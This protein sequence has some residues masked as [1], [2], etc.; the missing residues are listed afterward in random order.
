MVTPGEGPLTQVALERSVTSV[1]PVVSGQLIR[2]RELPAT[3]LPSAVVGLL[4]RVCPQ[5]GLE[6]AGLG[7][8]LV[9][10]RVGARVGGLSLAPPRAAASLLGLRRVQRGLGDEEVLHLRGGWRGDDLV[11][12]RTQVGAGEFAHDVLGPHD[13]LVVGVSH[14]EHRGHGGDLDTSE[15]IVHFL[16]L[17]G[18]RGRQLAG[19]HG[20]HH[21]AGLLGWDLAGDLVGG[22]EVCPEGGV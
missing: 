16:V 7:V 1:F 12:G 18:G 8:G 20:E 14:G 21:V 19:G 11:G 6:V 22:K 3:A 4:P 17:R 5:V 10:A 2:P 13:E 15:G 9:A